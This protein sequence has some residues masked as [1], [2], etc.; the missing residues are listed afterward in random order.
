MGLQ[1]FGPRVL[2][3]LSPLEAQIKTFVDQGESLPTPVVGLALIDTGASA[4]CIDRNA[5]E[6]AGL[7]LVDSGPMTSAT[8]DKEIVPIF[9]GRLKLEGLEQYVNAHRA[10]GATLES[11]GLI[12]LIGRDVLAGCVLVYNGPDGSFSLSI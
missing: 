4:T 8:H 6:R 7:A 3:T 10:Y 12:A 5:A 1:R 2:I 11:Q 9:A